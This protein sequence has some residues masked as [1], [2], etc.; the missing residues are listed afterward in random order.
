M[1]TEQHGVWPAR[2]ALAAYAALLVFLADAAP[3]ASTKA[4]ATVMS[5][6]LERDMARASGLAI[7]RFLPL[8][9]LAVLALP[10][11][12]GRFDRLLR[13]FL[14]AVAISGAAAAVV[15][16]FAS[17]S[18]WSLPGALELA[19][20]LTGCLLGAGLGLTWSRGWRARLLLLPKLA[21]VLALVAGAGAALVY[22]AAERAPLDFEPA[23]VTSAEK[24]RLYRQFRA[25]NP[26]TIPEG[27]A[28]ELRLTARDLDLLIA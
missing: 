12:S 22:L 9:F 5:L 10:R 23:R 8:G 7:A 21:F 27:G 6:G 15:V 24:R 25:A 19:P 11:R 20:P 2:V 14:P 13:V 3:D 17:G 28:A 1:T 18:A 26:A 4:G 16:G